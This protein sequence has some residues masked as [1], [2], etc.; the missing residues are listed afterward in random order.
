MIKV[1]VEVFSFGNVHSVGGLEMIASHN[2]VNVVDSS[3]P[4]PDFEEV[5]GP[6]TSVSVFGL[7]LRVVRWVDVVVDV[8]VSF[9]PL[10]I[11]I[12]FEV[13]MC[14]VNSEVFADPT[15]KFQLLVDLIQK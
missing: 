3:W 15:G 2:V 8:S 5:S 10:L 14:G 7:I 11:I 13:L 4:E 9:I 6:D 12:L 1:R